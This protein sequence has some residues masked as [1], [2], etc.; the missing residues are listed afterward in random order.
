[1]P[2]ARPD[3]CR[4]GGRA[5][6]QRPAGGVARGCRRSRRRLV[7]PRRRARAARRRACAARGPARALQPAARRRSAGIR[8]PAGRPRGPSRGDQ[9]VGLVVRPVP[10]RG[11]DP[12]APGGRAR[13]PG[14]LP[15]RRLARLAGRRARVPR[16]PPGA[17]PVLRGPRRRDRSRAEAHQQHPRDALPRRP[18]RGRLP[19]PG[20]LSQRGGPRGRHRA[21]RSRAV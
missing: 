3:R 2:S 19:A 10:R 1:A 13:T 4:P 5:A 20:R 16:P 17:V 11:A 18:R 12:A 6:G 15:G 7:R 21:L 8:A 14:R 9:Q